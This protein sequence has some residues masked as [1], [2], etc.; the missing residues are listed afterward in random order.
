[1][2]LMTGTQVVMGVWDGEAKRSMAT[3]RQIVTQVATGTRRRM[4]M[5][6]VRHI[7]MAMG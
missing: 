7:R 4:E 3:A 6:M 5:P 2:W 1:M